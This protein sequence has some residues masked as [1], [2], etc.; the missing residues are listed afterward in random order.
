MLNKH[1]R[2]AGFTLLEVLVAG[3]VLFVVTTAVVGL[4][5]SIIRGTST[6]ADKTI[7]NRWASE[8]LELTNKIR[9]DSVK[10]G[11]TAVNGESVWFAQAASVDKYGWYD[12]AA[13]KVGAV[14]TW[15]L[16]P[17][18]APV[19]LPLADAP[20]YSATPL[21]SQGLQ[22]TR[23]ICVEA[24]GAVDVS[25]DSASASCNSRDGTSSPVNDGDRVPS[26]DCSSTD[27]YCLL[28][29]ASLNRNHS[30]A[31][32]YIPSGNMVKIRSVVIWPDHNSFRTAELSTLF[33][34]WQDSNQL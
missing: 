20:S 23:L 8:G 19:Q 30:T 14:T 5:N 24:Y 1:I 28:I 32:A 18:S 15:Q 21:E 31:S 3:S 6:N 16:N 29:K 7:A 33:G 34:N 17:T 13:N 2:C 22:A 10:S 25:S 27:T 12:L 4:S 9:N 11:G 26:G